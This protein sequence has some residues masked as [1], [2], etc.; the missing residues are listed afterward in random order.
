M[1]EYNKI[2]EAL[3]ID[4]RN[5][6]IKCSKCEE[7]TST[8]LAIPISENDGVYCERCLIAENALLKRKL[9]I[10]LRGLDEYGD[11]RSWSRVAAVGGK[12]WWIDTENGYDLARRIKAEI[13]EV[14]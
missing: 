5:S 2:A 6:R 8:H 13:E 10:A 14:K 3:G 9:E 12:D 1:T 4:P 11:K 7:W